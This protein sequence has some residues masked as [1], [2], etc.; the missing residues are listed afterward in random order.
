VDHVGVRRH[1]H[2]GTHPA[3]SAIER[4]EEADRRWRSVS[5]TAVQEHVR[6]GFTAGA[7]MLQELA[8][9]LNDE[10]LSRREAIEKAMAHVRGWA[11]SPS[12]RLSSAT[13]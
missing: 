7:K 3:D 5:R 1:R 2:L 10:D 13:A 11:C 4:F 6:K 12:P 9:A 8:D